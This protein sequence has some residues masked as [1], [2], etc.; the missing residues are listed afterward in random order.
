MNL[1]FLSITLLTII[2][3]YS[4]KHYYHYYHYYK[5]CNFYST[6]RVVVSLTTS[7]QRIGYIKPVIDAMMNQTRK[8][9]RIYL[10]LPKLFLRNNTSFKDP[11]PDFI[12]NNPIVYV[13]FCEDI[14]PAT[15]I[16]PTIYL[17]NHPET[18][19]LSIDDDIYYPPTLIEHYLKYSEFFD[20]CVITGASFI[21]NKSEDDLKWFQN[22][23]HDLQNT[24][25]IYLFRGIIADLFEGFSG[26]LYTRKFFNKELI[27][28][29]YKHL[30]GP[31]CKFGDDFYLSNWFKKYGIRII[32]LKMQINWGH[33]DKNF[34]TPLH[35]GL[36]EDALHRGGGGF[37]GGNNNN[38]IKS[39][40]YLKEQNQLYIDYFLQN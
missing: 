36:N 2:I 29:F 22:K 23:L 26:I 4:I 5:N 14:G 8:P 17:E 13:N 16:I 12:T 19:I 35:Y 33:P 32:A 3:L 37:T 11:L 40:K 20:D 1:K 34:I 30:D 28:D 27:Q 15:K 39:T 18:K 24:S 10:N 7:P 9:D 25:D 38:Y 31:G 6:P 21:H